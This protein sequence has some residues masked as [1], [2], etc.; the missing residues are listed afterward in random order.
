VKILGKPRN[1]LSPRT[2]CLRPAEN[3]EDKGPSPLFDDV[4]AAS[5]CIDEVVTQLSDFYHLKMSTA[6]LA[7]PR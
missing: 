4:K 5:I 1:D 7:G 2:P 3:E 6:D